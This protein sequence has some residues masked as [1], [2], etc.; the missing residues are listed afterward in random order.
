MEYSRTKG[1]PFECPECRKPVKIA[2]L[3]KIQH[4]AG[5]QWNELVDVALE[6]ANIDKGRTEEEPE[7]V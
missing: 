6:W 5:S 7:Y 3:Q 2:D 4:T 1:N